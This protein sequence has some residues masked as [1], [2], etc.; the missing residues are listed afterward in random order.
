MN[1]F[2]NQIF[3]FISFNESVKYILRRLQDLEKVG[4]TFKESDSS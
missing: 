2:F 3:V 1:I 4:I